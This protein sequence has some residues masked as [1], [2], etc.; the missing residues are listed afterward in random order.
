MIIR[1]RRKAAPRAC[2]RLVCPA[3][4]FLAAI[5]P[6][7]LIRKVD[8]HGNAALVQLPFLDREAAQAELVEG[9]LFSDPAGF[10]KVLGADDHHGAQ[11]N[12]VGF[13]EGAA[14][15]KDAAH[16]HSNEVAQVIWDVRQDL[17]GRRHRLAQANE[18]R[19]MQQGRDEQ[20][21]LF[22]EVDRRYSF[23][24]QKNG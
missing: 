15:Q 4:H 9:F 20:A 2:L 21:N 6:A 1:P 5:Q 3:L 14:G 10:G 12:L 11:A 18:E 19:A 8:L 23:P 22:V 13:D 16:F 7:P 17:L 24:F